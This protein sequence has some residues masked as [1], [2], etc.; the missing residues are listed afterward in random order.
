LTL[1]KA[2]KKYQGDIVLATSMGVDSAVLLHMISRID[3]SLP[4]IFLDTGKH[5]R[6]TLGYRDD[7]VSRFGLTGNRSRRSRWKAQS[8]RAR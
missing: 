1:R 4:V 2:I 6:E 8:N 5:F 3:A 7:L